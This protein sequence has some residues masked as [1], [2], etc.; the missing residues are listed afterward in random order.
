MKLPEYQGEP[1]SVYSRITQKDAPAHLWHYTYKQTP[2]PGSLDTI[3][4]L[5]AMGYEQIP[6]KD[7][8]ERGLYLAC[9]F[10]QLHDVIVTQDGEKL[11][12]W[13]SSESLAFVKRHPV[14]LCFSLEDTPYPDT[15]HIQMLQFLPLPRHGEYAVVDKVLYSMHDLTEG[16]AKEKLGI[17]IKDLA[18]ESQYHTHTTTHQICASELHYQAMRT[19][20][21]SDMFS[22]RRK[23][24]QEAKQQLD[25]LD[26]A[27]HEVVILRQSWLRH[28]WLHQWQEVR[29]LAQKLASEYDD[30]HRAH[31]PPARMAPIPSSHKTMLPSNN[32]YRGIEESFGPALIKRSLWEDRASEHHIATPNGSLLK[33]KG[34]EDF[35]RKALT[36]YI[37]DMIGVEGLK[38]TLILLET[39]FTQTGG[40]DRRDDA[41]ISLRQLLIRMGY[42][43]TQADDFNER[44][45]LAH[46]ILYL[47]RTWVTSMETRY[48]EEIG[49]R[50]GRRG[51]GKRRRGVD[52]TPLLV[53]EKMRAS[54]DGGL[55][56]PDEVKFH[57]GEDFYNSMFGP[58]QQFF[59]LPTLAVLHYHAQKEQQELC[60]SFYLTNMIFVSKRFTIHFRE[61]AIQ[62][63]LMSE[64]EIE[65]DNQRIRSALRI[66]YALEHLERDGLIK[67]G[68]HETFD[69]V[70]AAEWYT[71]KCDERDLSP[72]TLQR[73]KRQYAYLQ[74]NSPQELNERRR[75]ALQRLLREVEGDALLFSPGPL[76]VKDVERR[77]Q[78]R[79]QA[80]A[81]NQRL[82][83]AR[84]AKK[85]TIVDAS[86]PQ[87]TN[88]IP[89]HGRE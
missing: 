38:H 6:G 28:D 74:G 66:V 54:A 49:P 18:G 61:M 47:A 64:E 35:E 30:H 69:M 24:R 88:N 19:S 70:L 13:A 43:E 17:A 56:V 76:T 36:Q 21:Y 73:I 79:D 81:R 42:S 34:Q 32:A 51:G 55:D 46:T 37:N 29:T 89:G 22:G 63:G 80:I 10:T 68:P 67:R 50:G 20:L 53:I 27:H 15:K 39:L 48:E 11:T 85:E 75:K 41:H 3:D 26:K 9:L 40:R 1:L 72:V 78:Q 87:E 23:E 4:Q 65:R 2:L 84:A 62:S 14:L 60:L 5:T 59:Y 45:K 33:V 57:L 71:Q 58:G 77:E 31:Q 25:L 44:K 83:E 16:T 7:D 82:I 12:H 86:P 8:K 52:W